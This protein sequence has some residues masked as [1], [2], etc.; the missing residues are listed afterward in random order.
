MDLETRNFSDIRNKNNFPRISIATVTRIF[1]INTH[2]TRAYESISVVP[3]KSLILKDYQGFRRSQ[4]LRK[5]RLV[6]IIESPS[7]YSM[8]SA[9]YRF[10]NS[11]RCTRD[12]TVAESR[13]WER[14][15]IPANLNPIAEHTT[16]EYINL[17]CA[18][19]IFPFDSLRRSFF[20][21]FFFWK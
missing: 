15:L 7:R 1:T 8:P 16:R 3:S 11:R 12:F 9:I 18:Q 14:E 20:L 13:P 6:K 5:C 2:L 19:T 10:P 4:G 21:F 17:D